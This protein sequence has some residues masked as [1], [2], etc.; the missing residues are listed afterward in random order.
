MKS[1]SIVARIVTWWADDCDLA[2]MGGAIAFSGFR[3]FMLGGGF[4]IYKAI[5]RKFTRH[6]RPFI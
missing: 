2:A 3:A 4:S 1:M 6:A 5:T